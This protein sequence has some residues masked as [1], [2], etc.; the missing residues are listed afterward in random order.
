VRTL[1][2]GAV[3]MLAAV[4]TADALRRDGEPQPVAKRQAAERPGE[5]LLRPGARGF[6][7]DG[8]L[9]RTRVLRG[10]REV[11]SAEQ[12]ERAF[13]AP[14]GG[15]Q[16]HIAHLAVAPDGTLA[17]AVYKFPRIGPARA[18]IELWR[19]NELAGAFPV[20]AG[21]FGGGLGFSADGERIATFSLRRRQATLFDRSGR[22]EAYV[23]VG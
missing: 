21:S 4:A 6:V 15:V 23:P 8:R 12:I 11:L 2:T 16:F 7:A 5:R 19:G 1:V 13:P 20:P 17:V 18:A 22:W 14:L 3:L 9:T 10:G